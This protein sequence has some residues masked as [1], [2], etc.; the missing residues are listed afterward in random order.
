[1]A[2]TDTG[3]GGSGEHPIRTVVHSGWSVLTL[4]VGV[5]GLFALTLIVLLETTKATDAAAILGIVIPAVVTIAAA[6]FG[7]AVASNAS[8]KSAEAEK[9]KAKAES[10]KDVAEEKAAKSEEKADEVAGEA[11]RRIEEVRSAVEPLLENLRTALPS[12][13]G[14]GEFRLEPGEMLSGTTPLV[15]GGDDL[16]KAQASIEAAQSSIRSL[17]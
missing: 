4:F 16:A 15:V 11:T 13:A 1:M 2:T 6:A 14:S 5:L 17:T 3:A 8:S 9:G 10:A 12:P 7:L